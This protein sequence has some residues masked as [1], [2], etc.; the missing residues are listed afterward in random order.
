MAADREAL[1]KILSDYKRLKHLENKDHLTELTECLE[2]AFNCMDHPVAIFDADLKIIFANKI[3]RERF[4]DIGVE[5]NLGE[6]RQ[7][8]IEKVAA[9]I[10]NFTTDEERREFIR[11]Q[12][13]SF[14]EALET[15]Q[16]QDFPRFDGT[17]YRITVNQTSGGNYVYFQTDIT[18]EVRRER[19]L[20]T[21]LES[22][23][24]GV[25]FMDPE[26]R[27]QLMNPA[28]K[29]IMELDEFEVT[30]RTYFDDIWKYVR[31]KGI[32]AGQYDD[33]GRWRAFMQ[34][35]YSVA[36]KASEEAQD[37]SL[38]EDKFLKVLVKKFDDGRMMT[39]ISDVTPLVKKQRALE[40]ETKR[41]QSAERAKSEFLANM[42]HEIRTPMNGVMGMAELLMATELDPRQQTFADTIVKSGDALLT[43]INDILDFSKID[44][45]QI[46]LQ[47]APFELREAVEDVM[48]LVAPRV[49]RKNIEL[50]VR[51]APS[52]PDMFVGDVGRIRQIVTNLVGNAV[53]FTEQGHVVVEVSGNVEGEGDS[54]TGN[55]LLR[56]EDTGVG[57]PKDQCE[58]I[59]EKFSQVDGSAARKHEGTG[60]G[61]SITASLIE[62]MGGVIN[63]ESVVNEGSVFTVRLSLPV[64]EEQSRRRSAP[65]DVSGARVLIVDDN[66]VNRAILQEQTTAWGFKSKT[67][68]DGAAGLRLL[69]AAEMLDEPFDLVIMDYHMPEMTG[70]D[71]VEKIKANEKLSQTPIVML[72]SVDQTEDGKQFASLGVA[73]HLT[74]PARS[75]LLMETLISTV[76]ETRGPVEDVDQIEGSALQALVDKNIANLR[77][78][79][80]E[81]EPAGTEHTAPAQPVARGTKDRIRILVAE[82]NQVNQVVFTQ[83]LN[84]LGVPFKIVENGVQAVEAFKGLSPEIVLMDISM[85]IMNGLDATASIREHKL[86]TG[87]HA[88]IIAV[89]AHA[90]TGDREKYL[91]SGMDDYL[92]KPISPAKLQ[93]MVKKWLAAA[94]SRCA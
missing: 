40:A 18:E 94:E 11:F 13:E 21:I 78:A 36:S 70:A 89:T 91:E 48:T 74:K 45:G 64:A 26:E 46:K 84:D 32:L 80:T 51:V 43:I 3:Y 27:V 25:I 71:A 60:L 66:E 87:G 73:A 44:A 23:D 37:F 17:H 90:M 52:L 83:S 4:V 93:D 85:P 54:A 31:K 38:T 9:A 33:D 16:P 1:E 30:P 28:Y 79:V 42:S 14:N 56:V 8:I 50:A 53:K 24:H 88:P 72:T 63:V 47:T 81:G 76:Q 6:D 62:L 92:A 12:N 68:A 61:L 29:A 69:E 55:L 5:F 2:Q 86:E 22:T 67:A 39:S 58:T 34:D 19:D 10:P 15:G 20:L 41:A 7:S 35:L 49:A 77:T 82:D 75:S 59:F 57:I 65:V